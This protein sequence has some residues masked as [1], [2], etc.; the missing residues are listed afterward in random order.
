MQL[1]PMPESEG[2]RCW[3]SSDEQAKLIDHL[4][5]H[6]TRQIAAR[7]M[8][9]GL[10]T[11]ELDWLRTD[12]IRRLDAEREAY[13]L[14]VRDGKTGYREVPISCDLKQQLLMLK[15]AKG[16][17]QDE[18]LVDQTN[19]TIRRWIKKAG[20]E[21]ADELDDDDWMEMSPHDL[22]RTW[23]TSTYYALD[24]HYAVDI[25]MRWGGWS[26]R[27]TFVN[28]YLGRETDPMAAE[29]MQTAGLR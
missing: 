22:R 23:A 6:P 20:S 26:S 15:N 1:E 11:D 7:A 14:R 17:H 27:E 8:L 13:K 5:E 10:R 25:V 24:S 18:Q 3:L 12:G 21:L 16:K 9:H 2:S 19:R 28:N 4:T 29:M